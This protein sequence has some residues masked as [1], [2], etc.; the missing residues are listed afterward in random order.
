[1]TL[2]LG[3][4]SADEV[5]RSFIPELRRCSVAS[6]GGEMVHEPLYA[7]S[8]GLFGLFV[9]EPVAGAFHD[10]E[11]GLDLGFLE[12]RIRSLAVA[13]RDRPVIGAVDEEGRGIVGADLKDGG[14]AV[15][16]FLGEVEGGGAL[17]T[18]GTDVDGRDSRRRR[19]PCGWRRVTRDRRR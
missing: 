8:G 3:G 7:G 17:A 14:D 6:V 19:P 5:L 4:P 10:D 16:V 9:A 11:L 1:M 2:V 18:P 13:Q 15:A 12:S